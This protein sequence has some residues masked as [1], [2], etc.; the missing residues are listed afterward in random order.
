MADPAADG[1]P[2]DPTILELPGDLVLTKT[3][4]RSSVLV[5]D[6]VTY[7]LTLENRSTGALA[8]ID[9]ADTLPTGF[10][11][12][13]ST[14][15][16]DGVAREPD[17]AG[18]ALTWAGVVVG[19]AE[20]ITITYDVYVGNSAGPGDHVNRAQGFDALTGA[21]RTD[22]ATATVRIEAEPVF[23]CSTVIGRVFDD[24]N[25]DGYFNEEPQEDRMAI[26]DQTYYGGKGG[27]WS[28]PEPA[29][30]RQEVGLPG[31]RLVTPNGT[32]VTTD[33]HGRFSLPC[34][35]LPRDI[36]ANFMLKIDDRTLPVGYRMTTENPR[37][38][39]LTP[40]MLTKMNFGAS[41]FPI[42]RIDLSARAF[43]GDGEMRPEFQ[44]GLQS[45]VNQIAATPSVVRLGYQV[46]SGEAERAARAR[47]RS[48]EREIRRLWADTG[49]YALTIER[50]IERAAQASS[51]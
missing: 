44:V 45:L 43:T 31:V 29:E 50:V 36:G 15:V 4:N 28:E 24:V 14:A 12:R 27:K 39:R 6:V 37:V 10:V 35:A 7:T 19:A 2:D 23:H 49:R 5:G 1:G 8:N 48:V 46:S 42:A 34:A 18:Q 16:V 9:F 17:I 21:P 20:T 3:V 38:V 47:M 41:M 51:Q 11:Y 26:T 22:E 30:P 40:G 33:E 13:A 32:A 25:H